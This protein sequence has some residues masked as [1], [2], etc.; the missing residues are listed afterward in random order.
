MK[1]MAPRVTAAEFKVNIVP[2]YT[3]KNVLFVLTIM[4][5]VQK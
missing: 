5:N 4:M 1:M 2:M 3:M